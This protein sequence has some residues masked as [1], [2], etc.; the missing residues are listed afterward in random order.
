MTPVERKRT[1]R[2]APKIQQGPRIR[3]MTRRKTEPQSL[4]RTA[5]MPMRMAERSLPKEL[6]TRT[7]PTRELQRRLDLP[8]TTEQRSW[9][10]HPKTQG[11]TTKHQRLMAQQRLQMEGR[12]MRV[13]QSSMTGL[14]TS[15][16]RSLPR[17][18]PTRGS[19]SLMKGQKLMG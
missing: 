16:R 15:G 12:L 3:L 7:L 8:P 11:R 6:L 18:L 17:E 5:Q 14:Q 2:H 13:P 4:L 19:P 9:P 1:T 10:I